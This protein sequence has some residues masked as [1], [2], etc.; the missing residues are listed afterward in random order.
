MINEILSFGYLPAVVLTGY[1]LLSNL[2]KRILEELPFV[3]IAGLSF[4]LGL[5]AWFPLLLATAWFNVFLPHIIG[6]LGWIAS[7]VLIWRLKRS[8]AFERLRPIPKTDIGILLFAATLFVFNALFVSESILGGRDQGVYATHGAHIANTAMLKSDL[9]YEKLY[10]PENY[11][12][13][14]PTNPNGYS[15]DIPNG[16]IF[17]QFPPTFALHLAQFFGIGDY[18]GLLLFNPLVASISVF[19]FF[20]L[21]SLFMRPRWAVVA[22]LFYAMNASQIWNARITLSEILAQ[23]IL[24]A[25]LL[26]AIV[27]VRQQIPRAYWLGC[28]V[29]SAVAFARV[30]AFLF[31]SFLAIANAGLYLLADPFKENRRTYLI[32]AV[33]IIATSLVAYRFN[34]M[35]SPAYFGDFSDKV[36]WMIFI[37]LSASIFLAAPWN[38]RFPKA[39][40]SFLG[41]RRFIQGSIAGLA[42]LAL[43]AYFVRPYIEPFAQFADSHYGTRNYRENSLID[44]SK[45]LSLP[46]IVFMVVGAGMA[47]RAI[48]RNS[49]VA[50]ILFFLPWFGFSLI[51]LFDPQ[52]SSDHIWRIR[53]F[54]P[55]II[56]G[57]ILVAIWAISNATDRLRTPRLRS[58]AMSA[59][60][61]WLFGFTLYSLQPIAF[62]K[63]Y[64]GTLK[65]VRAIAAS[66]PEDSLTL[67]NVTS[68]ILG[69]L[70]LAEGRKVIRET[71]E[72][73]PSMPTAIA[74]RILE[75][76]FESGRDLFI[77]SQHPNNQSNVLRPIGTWEH[78]VPHLKRTHFAPANEVEY[79]KRTF[80]L[81]KLTGKLSEVLID[82]SFFEF[83]AA[84]MWNV[85]ETGMHGQEY[86]GP[87]PFRWTMGDATFSISTKFS[88]PP[89]A[90]AINWNATSPEGSDLRVLYNDAEVRNA[91]LPASNGT[92]SIPL[93]GV[94]HR[95]DGASIRIVSNKWVPSET[96]EGSQ[97]ARTLGIAI[98][99]ITL[100]FDERIRFENAVFG[101]FPV[102]G[103]DESGLHPVEVVDGLWTRWT[104]EQ[105][106]FEL[107]FSDQA[108][109]QT[110]ELDIEGKIEAKRPLI[111]TWN[112][113]EI[114]NE[115]L[116]V[117]RVTLS[118]PIQRSPQDSSKATL[119][120]RTTP[121]VP[122]EIGLNS[123]VRA[124][125][126]RIYEA[127]ILSD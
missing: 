56:P 2:L 17:I 110:L 37:S 46:I 25:G 47:F 29:V 98:T 72:S 30:D 27:G 51:Y 102:R 103:I 113:R 120:I 74:T 39:L 60:A 108:D 126:A 116:S 11:S 43:Y 95:P 59:T 45:Y 9:P 125:G 18:E 68:Q 5:L 13:A 48:C 99:G 24:F 36:L 32:A 20:S 122:A 55:I 78:K 26:I 71:R 41:S 6:L 44:L 104:S 49:N 73:A 4:A 79:E 96:I 100:F 10:V 50:L 3:G 85:D 89:V 83:G 64:E 16:D 80:Y 127:R 93:N 123:D 40:R 22:S 69:P 19:T 114:Y 53:R 84:L 28:A 21:A 111:V 118:I 70:Q 107:E 101:N 54:T 92:I 76:E 8:N 14:G 117:D 106:T 97:D 42:L 38:S 81:S 115:T 77:L 35:T 90:M 119:E 121:I 94:P 87:L 63:Q 86:N 7:G 34:A 67:A 91:T 31:P 105:A 65:V 112:D 33:G 109:P 12:L 1:W 66:L 88:R 57:A 75:E 58:I 15:Y 82:Q 23:N 62:L 124:L 61:L 52:I